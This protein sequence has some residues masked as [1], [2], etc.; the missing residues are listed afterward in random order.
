MLTRENQ[1]EWI[2]KAAALSQRAL[3]KEVA[4]AV[5][6]SAV[7]ERARVLGENQIAL[8]M[9]I[10]EALF[11]KLKRVQDLESKRTK[12]SVSLA[13]ALGALA[14]I[15]LERKDPVQQAVKAAEKTG[16]QFL[17]TVRA[18]SR[19]IPA[20]AKHRVYLRDRGRCQYPGCTHTHWT[21]IHHKIPLHQ[22]GTHSPENLQTLC[23]AHHKFVHR[24]A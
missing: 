17:R 24:C 22:G 15:Y 2:S 19:A 16:Q 6:E 18:K 11:Q 23:V 21:E 10:S 1:E 3:E 9:P 14:D 4:K 12:R 7:R 8:Q 5:P 13:E 20:A